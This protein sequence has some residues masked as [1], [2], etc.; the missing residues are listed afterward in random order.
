VYKV[1]ISGAL[2]ATNAV[3]YLNNCHTMMEY[4]N[5][6]K[7]KGFSVY[8]PCLELL[9]GLK[10]GYYEYEDYFD[11][12]QPWLKCSDAIFVCP[13]SE[14][15]EGT[16]KEI[17]TARKLRIPVFHCIEKLDK[18][19]NDSISIEVSDKDR[20]LN[21]ILPFF[22]TAYI[23]KNNE[24]IIEPKNNVYFRIDN[25]NSDLEFDC[26]IL[27]FVSRVSCKHHIK[28]WR[29]YFRRG[30]NSYFKINWSEEEMMK[31]YTYLGNG[32]N[33]TLCIEFIKSNYDL[34]ILRKQK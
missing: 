13:N 1:Y 18:Y 6:V 11:N 25:I 33:R 5:K 31:I 19:F 22:P 23:Y 24:I 21:K 17:R 3:K 14:N 32:V 26:K 12:S 8:I 20:Y 27:E 9:M 15:S 30:M 7:D 29:S 2:N 34:D 10:F 16:Q 4:A 28:Y